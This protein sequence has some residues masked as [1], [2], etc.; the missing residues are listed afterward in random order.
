MK[1]D[2]SNIKPRGVYQLKNGNKCLLVATKNIITYLLNLTYAIDFKARTVDPEFIKDF[3]DGKIELILLEDS[4][5]KDSLSLNIRLYYWQEQLL[6]QGVTF[7]A[8]HKKGTN[9]N[10]V[11]R[12][13]RQNKQLYVHAMLKPSHTKSPSLFTTVGVFKSMEEAKAW[14]VE[15]YGDSGL[16]EKVV[17]ANNDHTKNYFTRN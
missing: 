8:H 14:G 12:I 5:F 11:Y 15:A 10:L 9:Y 1:I 13:I 4:G 17:Y 6:K 2:L 16:I 3:K 7:Y